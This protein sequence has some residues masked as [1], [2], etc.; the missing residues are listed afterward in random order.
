MSFNIF[1]FTVSVLIN[2]T[3]NIFFQDQFEQHVKADAK[4]NIY[5]YYGPE[6]NKNSDFLSKQDVVLTTY[7]VVT[8]DY[9]VSL[10]LCLCTRILLNYGLENASQVFLIQSTVYC[11]QPPSNLFFAAVI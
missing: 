10:L 6:R 5:I 11:S 3:L 1:L 7:N 4:L 8:Y 9:A 2:N